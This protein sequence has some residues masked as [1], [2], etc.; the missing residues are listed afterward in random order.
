MA[1]YGAAMSMADRVLVPE[2]GQ[3]SL[4]GSLA[5]LG[6]EAPHRSCHPGFTSRLAAF[7]SALTGRDVRFEHPALFLTKGQVMRDLAQLQPDTDAWLSEHYSCSY[8]SR[9][10]NIDGRR[11]HCGLC[12][13]CQL[14]RM[15]LF[16]ASIEDSTKYRAA[17]LSAP[18][19]EAAF[20]GDKLPPELKSY[21]D[22]ALNAARGMQRVASLALTPNSLRVWSEIDGL[23]RCQGRSVPDTKAD[24]FSFLQRHR[25]EW[26]AFLAHCGKTSWVSQLAKG[27]S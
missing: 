24:M 11:V 3:G 14:R 12:G 15:S 22:V 18:S 5:P 2:N 9:H 6:N 4:G 13:N 20:S 16:A 17:S 26:E 21:R 19:L 8:D 10:A 27:Y 23:A 7:V 1:A 25:D